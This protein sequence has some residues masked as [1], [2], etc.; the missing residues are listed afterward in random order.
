V[1]LPGEP[2]IRTTVPYEKQTITAAIVR[3]K[4]DPAYVIA[5]SRIRAGA[6]PALTAKFLLHGDQDHH[7][8]V[9]RA[10][11]GPGGRGEKGRVQETPRH[12]PRQGTIRRAAE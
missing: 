6:G 5:G 9:S 2:E 11:D 1:A 4:H 12:Q 8:V 3:S 7:W 10:F